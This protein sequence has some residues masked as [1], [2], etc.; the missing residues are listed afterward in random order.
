MG[1]GVASLGA[2]LFLETVLLVYG[3]S[4][5]A[6]QHV[7]SMEPQGILKQHHGALQEHATSAAVA[8]TNFKGAISS[9]FVPY[10]G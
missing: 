6:K 9:V 10:L 7:W 8:K 3:Q 4:S 2:V 5:A 1:C